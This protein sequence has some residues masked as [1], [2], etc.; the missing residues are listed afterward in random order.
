MVS[1]DNWGLCRPMMNSCQI[2]GSFANDF[3]I[4][5][6][7]GGL[8]VAGLSAWYGCQLPRWPQCM[9]FCDPY[10]SKFDYRHIQIYIQFRNIFK[11]QFMIRLQHLHMKP[12]PI[13]AQKLNLDAPV[14]RWHLSMLWIWVSLESSKY[15]SQFCFEVSI[16]VDCLNFGQ[17]GWESQSLSWA[18]KN[19]HL[20]LFIISLFNQLCFW[21]DG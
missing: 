5:V 1:K 7:S 14:T 9:S 10:V 16:Q 20:G 15:L 19:V 4:G 6:I 13:I 17:A 12:P 3:V 18:G 11:C 21:S 8:S 2:N